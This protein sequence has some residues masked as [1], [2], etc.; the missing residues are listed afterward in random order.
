MLRNPDEL[1]KIKRSTSR[2]PKQSM[3]I[4]TNI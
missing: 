3:E 2:N 1:E 4:K